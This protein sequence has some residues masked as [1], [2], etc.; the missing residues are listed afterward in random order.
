MSTI[1]SRETSAIS[2]D[3][4]LSL[5]ELI[6]YILLSSLLLSAMAVVLVNSWSTQKDVASVTQATNRGQVIGSA[7]ERAMR[8]ALDFDVD[9]ATGT[10]LRV[11]TSLG[12]NLACQAFLLK[13][14]DARFTTSSGALPTLASDWARW[15]NGIAQYASTPFFVE[16][17]DVVTYTFDIE[18]DSAPVR[19]SGEAAA[20][21]TATG[22]SSPCW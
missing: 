8:N 10:E 20:R 14:G 13:D 6:I 7:I 11:R 1:E 18:T 16:N 12:G 22:V 21:S 3:A 5:I 19:F 17:G 2:G 9:D 4:G 15:E